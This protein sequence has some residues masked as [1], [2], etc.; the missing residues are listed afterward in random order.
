[1]PESSSRHRLSALLLALGLVLTVAGCAPHATVSKP[2]ATGQAAGTTAGEDA[3]AALPAGTSLVA[4]A[5]GPRVHVY[6]GPAGGSVTT[7]A[8]PSSTSAPLTFLVVTS[9]AGRLRVR[10]PVR[11]NG[12]TGWVPS[13]EVSL[14]VTPYQLTVSLSRRRLELR[15]NGL[16]A[17]TFRVGVGRSVTP[18]PPGTYYLTELLQPA[19]PHGAY[20][21]YAF[22]LSAF[23]TT[24]HRFAGGPGQLGL[25]GTDSPAGLGHDVS[26]GCI[27]L[28]NADITELA[29]ELPLG[30][31]IR[32]EK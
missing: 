23:S 29:G 31:P 24:L 28:A 6:S 2:A 11:P 13:S 15:R 17:K 21:P 4:T 14:A 32:I 22:G 26:H 30:T 19:D 12:A 3:V 8:N 1:V 9:R 27:R 16:L 20:G 18:T 5:R 10:L 25:H 7:L